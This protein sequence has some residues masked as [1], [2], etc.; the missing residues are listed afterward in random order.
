MIGRCCI[1][2]VLAFTVGCNAMRTTSDPPGV[3]LRVEPQTVAPGASI[4]LILENESGAQI[5]YN[6][7]TSAL[8]RVV[9]G[10]AQA[11]PSDRICTM[12]LRLL[13]SSQ[14]ARYTL[15]LPADLSAGDYR[16]VAR[17]ERMNSAEMAGVTSNTFRV[18]R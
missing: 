1:M 4:E 14:N 5:G 17:I 8:E 6:L 3:S 7:C 12:E 18:R 13:E 16:M 11:V 2:I 9:N 15:Q 10:T